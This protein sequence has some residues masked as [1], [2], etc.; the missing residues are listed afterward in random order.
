M[1]ALTATSSLKALAEQ[2]KALHHG[3]DPQLRT[4]IAKA[5]QAGELLLQSKK[6]CKRQGKPFVPWMEA[7]GKPKVRECQIYM[8][9]F[10]NPERAAKSMNILDFTRLTK[11]ME[12]AHRR[13]NRAELIDNAKKLL[14]PNHINWQ[15]HC[16]DN[17]KFNWRMLDHIWTDPVWPKKP[18]YKE[19]EQY[20][21][22]AEMAWEKLK[23]GGLLAVQCP[24][25]EFAKILPIFK[26]FE[27]IWTLAIVYSQ[28]KNVTSCF[29]MN[30]KP[31][32][33]FSKGATKLPPA[34]VS[35]MVPVRPSDEIEKRYDDWQQPLK[36]M[37]RWIEA[38]TL[39]GQL[40][41]DPFAG[42][43]TNLV[44]SKMTGR[45]GIG[46]DIRPEMVAVARMRLAE[47]K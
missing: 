31:V 12:K 34:S 21:W 10:L 23:P 7:L 5:S 38:L 20:E 4:S 42:S 46:T 2:I 28:A 3:I 33:L 22:L 45:R 37:K 24:Q 25:S 27:Y 32:L 15:V 29:L 14:L 43:G 6:L 40:I 44:A 17:R 8:Q 30:W 35:D 9:I 36:P 41:G 16:A 47:V 26:K 1:E 18:D 39:P 19:L 13:E 11:D